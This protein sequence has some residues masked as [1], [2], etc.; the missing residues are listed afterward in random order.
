M[1]FIDSSSEGRLRGDIV[2]HVRSLG[3]EHSQKTFEDCLLFLAQPTP[4][5]RRLIVYDNVDD[6]NLKLAPL[7]PHGSSCTIIIT[8]RDRL[9]GGLN[10]GA[11]LELDVMST[12]EAVELVL[13]TSSQST[14]AIE[15]DRENARDIAEALGCLPLAL[16]QACSYMFQTKCSARTYLELLSTSR[17]KLLSTEL[18]YQLHKHPISTYAAFD[19]SFDKL[20]RR[21]QQFL[22]LLAFFHW[23]NFPLELIFLAAKHNFSDY[24]TKYIDHGGSFQTGKNLL[25]DIFL[26]DGVWDP[27]IMDEMTKSIQ[28]YSLITLIPGV[29]TTLL[30]MHPLTHGWI[31]SCIPEV[32]Q[33]RYQS[34]AILLLALGARHQDTPS[35]KHLPSHAMH[36]TAVWDRLGVNDAEAFARILTE[37]GLFNNALGL[38]EMVVAELR[39][40]IDTESLEF[41]DS[42]WLLAAA[43]SNVGRFA[44]AQALQA[45]VMSLR[46]G[47][48]QEN[49]PTTLEA[50]ISLAN[51]YRILRQFDNAEVMQWEVL[52]LRRETLGDHNTDTLIALNQLALTYSESGRPEK[53]EQL[54][55]EALALSK[56]LQRDRHPDTLIVS[57][58]LANT[59]FKLKRPKEALPLQLEV[60]RLSKEVRGDRHPDTSKAMSQLALIYSALGE[61]LDAKVLQEEVQT[62]SKETHGERHPVTISASSSLA[63]IYYQMGRFKAAVAFQEEVLRLRGGLLGER[64]LD[65]IDAMR[66]LAQTYFS[67][68]RTSE[69]DWLQEE[70]WRRKTEILGEK[71]PDTI[72][73][74]RKLARVWPGLSR[75][76]QVVSKR[77]RLQEFE[78][79][80]LAK[81]YPEYPLHVRRFWSLE[82]RSSR[83][84]WLELWKWQTEHLGEHHPDTI[85][86]LVLVAQ[87]YRDKGRLLKAELLQQKVLQ[88]RKKTLGDRHPFT[89]AAYFALGI[90][91]RYMGQLARAES[92]HLQV[93]ASLKETG[94]EHHPDAIQARL[95]LAHVYWDLG[96]YEEAVKFEDEALTHFKEVFGLDKEA[97]I[98]HRK[99]SGSAVTIGKVF[100]RGMSWAESILDRQIV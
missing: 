83:R 75:F 46:K 64:N 17:N 5:G 9:M 59:Y 74:G 51:T 47:L 100:W 49:D 79:N 91:Y 25:E 72:E 63:T 21:T 43:Y 95:S 22:R 44:E 53:A 84:S 38:R 90:T 60:V 12:D 4:D 67:L 62:L 65:T 28:N 69:A 42:L 37:G 80:L 8:S 30:Q 13:H 85:D 14:S 82:D 81:R 18:N 61:F 88:S 24:E 26:R 34:A 50:Y 16:Q 41:S 92:L 86:A 48:M 15:Q 70:A 57:G 94:R 10:P 7:L 19:A 93:L 40:Q 35:A 96:R 20:V 97:I 89:T 6:P 52:K 45:Q 87:D 11:H 77:E 2:R 98:K 66:D 33:D 3:P 1:F 32:D 78:R 29:D 27:T 39:S 56:E 54:Q 99:Q 31:R 55:V 71:H 23:S 73:A 76:N 36:M 68:G 58:D